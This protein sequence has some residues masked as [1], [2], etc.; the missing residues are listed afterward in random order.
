MAHPATA[1]LQCPATF[2]LDRSPFT[3]ASSA[4]TLCCRVSRLGAA[5]FFRDVVFNSPTSGG[6]FLGQFSSC[7]EMPPRRVF[8]EQLPQALLGSL[9]Q[10]ICITFDLMAKLRGS[11]GLSPKSRRRRRS[12]KA[13]LALGL[14]VDLPRY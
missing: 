1:K 7:M 14:P 6:H 12:H 11:C 2:F 10:A 8:A 9:L 5:G 13:R 3:D 4:E